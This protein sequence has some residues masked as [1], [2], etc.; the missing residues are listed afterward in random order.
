LNN[1]VNE[2]DKKVVKFEVDNLLEVK[3]RL[4][5]KNESVTEEAKETPLH[6]PEWARNPFKDITNTQ[7]EV[8]P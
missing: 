6:I 2:D 5:N 3:L 1:L 4:P 8:K 7:N